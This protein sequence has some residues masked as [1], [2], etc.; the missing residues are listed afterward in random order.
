MIT[1]RPLHIFVLA[2]GYYANGELTWHSCI[3]CEKVF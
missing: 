1:Q 2:T 3:T